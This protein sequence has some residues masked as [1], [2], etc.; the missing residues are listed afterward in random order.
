MA[1]VRNVL[2]IAAGVAGRAVCAALALAVAWPAAAQS[3]SDRPHLRI[4]AGMHTTRIVRVDSD[5]AGRILVTASEDRTARVWD[6]ATGQLIQVLRVPIGGDNDGWVYSAAIAPDGQSVVLGGWMSYGASALGGLARAPGAEPDEPQDYETHS[7]FVY[8]LGSGRMLRRIPGLGNVANDL[9]YSP[10]GRHLAVAVGG[11]AR[12]LVLET[13][14]WTVVAELGM[15]DGASYNLAWS[16]DGRLAT[17]TYDGVIRLYDQS[18]RQVRA[19]RP[20]AGERPF[21]IAFSPDGGLLA[22]GYESMRQLLVLDGRTLA[23]VTEPDVTDVS[24]QADMGKVEWSADGSRLVAGGSDSFEAGTWWPRYIRVWEDRGAGAYQDLGISGNT[25]LDLETLPDGSLAVV[26]GQPDIIFLNPELKIAWQKDSPNF[27]YSAVDRSHFRMSGDGREIGATPYG[28]EPF[29][30]DVAGRSLRGEA[31]QHPAYRDSARGLTLTEWINTSAPRLNGRTLDFLEAYEWSRSVAVAQDGSFA[32]IGGDWNLY[33]V[34]PDGSQRWKA[35]TPGA[36]WTVNVSGDGRLVGAAY[37]DGTIRWYDA[38]DGTELLALYVHADG[39]RWVLWTPSGYYDAAPGGE[40]LIGWH[41]NRGLETEP[42]FFGAALFRDRYY[43]PDVVQAI[44]ATRDEA[45]AVALADA[46]RN[47]VAP[48]VGQPPQGV[49]LQNSLPPVVRIDSPARGDL[50]RGETLAVE[51]GVTVA[52]DAP[53]TEV[54][55]FINGRPQRD[56]PVELAGDRARLMLD[57]AGLTEE[58]LW[59]TV[60]GA[61]RHGFGPPADV[62]LRRPSVDFR[63]V[64]VKPKL[65]VLAIGTSQ[66]RD[67]SLT[68]QYAAK[69]AADFASL[70]V[71]QEGALY[72]AVEVRLVTDTDATYDNIRDG[73]FWLEEEVTANDTAYIFLAGHGVNDNRGELFFLPHEAEVGNLRRTAVAA[74]EI[75]RT[76]EYLPGRTVYFMDSCHSGNLEFTRRAAVPL[77]VNGH[78]QDLYAATGAVVF[79]SATGSQYSLESPEWGNGAFTLALREGLDGRADVNGDGAVSVN[80]MN[81]YLSDRVK[82]LT[83][84]RQT[85]VLRKRDEVADFPLAVLMH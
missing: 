77:D 26:S 76:I 1:P 22:V 3:V 27:D 57:I 79:S 73:L 21:D 23:T 60:M 34:N 62:M 33:S 5:P 69:D 72:S 49:P 85:P 63:P 81:L 70:V 25:I 71:G 64:E 8:D 66:Y 78:L 42:V 40:D 15:N 44:L 16:P 38:G 82:E 17:V 32:V 20:Y 19:R 50:A 4:E 28:G 39:Q 48:P 37:A 11:G 83:A 43:R 52:P 36:A 68:L 6:T 2:G 67:A 74:S 18:F 55:V 46:R 9:A 61:N 65:Y 58:E 13:A 84:N 56:P 59:V 53:L 24:E 31:S 7:L 47:E 75:V 45:E 80:E 12:S 30:F 51:L 10:D 54:R 41:V 29:V 14:T 35:R